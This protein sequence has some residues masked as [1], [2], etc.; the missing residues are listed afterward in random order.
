MIAETMVHALLVSG[1]LT[2]VG[3]VIESLMR[4]RGLPRRWGWMG[5]IAGSIAITVGLLLVNVVPAP[6]PE[7]AG[8]AEVTFYLGTV[9]DMEANDAIASSTFTVALVRDLA[10]GSQAGLEG[11]ASMT[12]ALARLIER[13]PLGNAGL[14]LVWGILSLVASLMLIISAL[15]LRQRTGG[16]PVEVVGGQPFAVA[17]ALGPA[18]VGFLRPKIVLPRWLLATPTETLSMVVTH[19]E[20]HLRARDT[21]L[22]AGG[23]GAIVLAPWNPFVWIQL[24]RL[25]LAIELDCDARV[26][27][28]GVSS[29]RYAAVLLEVGSRSTPLPV[30]ATALA[31][32]PH[33]LERR[34][35]TL[36]SPFS[37]IS[38][39]RASLIGTV[40][41]L[42]IVAAFKTPTPASGLESVNNTL[43]ASTIEAIAP[44]EVPLES[45]TS[46]WVATADTLD[47]GAP[48]GADRVPNSVCLRGP[49]GDTECT[50]LSGNPD[51]HVVCGTDASGSWGCSE[52]AGARAS[53]QVCVVES[54]MY[55]CADS[56][57]TYNSA[58]REIIIVGSGS[59]AREIYSG[60]IAPQGAS[61]AVPEIV[62]QGYGENARILIP[63]QVDTIVQSPTFTPYEIH[64]TVRNRD[65]VVVAIAREYPADLKEQGVGGQVVLHMFIDST[66]IVRN[67]QL[68][69]TSG[70]AALDDAALRVCPVFEFVP[71]Q[72]GGQ[73]VPVWVQ[74]PI[75]FNA[76]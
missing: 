7:S 10:R 9:A 17:E 55:L 4:G 18:V 47:A 27:G 43:P 26:V 12:G 72:N 6:A 50:E 53:A 57:I 40:A 58:G 70:S 76:R 73:P 1:I 75:S 24:S 13:N 63:A 15:R 49:D 56:M 19:E 20:E 66:G 69:R 59:Q 41:I 67:C 54:R 3:L 68:A 51:S 46:P 37:K 31:E 71:A 34:M 16:L 65:S 45:T 32:P 42:L 29:T 60:T 25:R 5:A 30:G 39:P 2:L 33:F 11:L 64:P 52:V 36:I 44:V 38:L 61:Q 48:E 22:L 35:K 28:R 62:V 8:G 74:I 14:A 21:L 23:L